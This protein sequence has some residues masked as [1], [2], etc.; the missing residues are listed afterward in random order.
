MAGR[1]QESGDSAGEILDS[2]FHF[3]FSLAWLL[4]LRLFAYFVAYIAFTYFIYA[5]YMLKYM[6]DA[7]YMPFEW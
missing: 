2:D 7:L 1:S 3:D 5:L 4:A 6:L